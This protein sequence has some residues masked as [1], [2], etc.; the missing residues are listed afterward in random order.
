VQLVDLAEVDP[1]D[2]EQGFDGGTV[3]DLA[4]SPEELVCG[5]VSG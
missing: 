4:S 1:A 3:V 2:A 5:F